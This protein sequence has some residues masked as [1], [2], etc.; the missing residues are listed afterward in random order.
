MFPSAPSY[1]KILPLIITSTI[2]V[3]TLI[4]HRD[5]SYQKIEKIEDKVVQIPEIPTND[6]EETLKPT[7]ILIIAFPR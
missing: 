7:K 3:I 5:L 4:T 2:C 6:F 1:Y